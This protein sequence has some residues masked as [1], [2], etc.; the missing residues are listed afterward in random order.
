MM[1]RL[2]VLML[3]LLTG[4]YVSCSKKDSKESGVTEIIF[5]SSM[6]G[7]MAEAQ[8]KIV[9]G[10]NASQDKVKVTAIYQGSYFDMVAKLQAAFTAGDAPHLA[11]LEIA[12]I[13]MFADYGVLYDMTDLAKKA[14][15]DTSMFYPGLMTN[16]DWGEGLLALPFNRSTPM[17][18]YN[19]DMFREVGLDPDRPP[20]NWTELYEYSKRLSISDRRWGYC[21]PIDTWF[22]EAFIFQSNGTVFNADS[23]DIG[24]NNDSGIIPLRLWKQWI[25]EGVMKSP[26][27]QEYNSW[28]AA[29]LDFSAGIVGMIVSSSGDLEGLRRA[30][31][32]EIGTCFLPAN[33]RY[34]VPTG[35]AN[36]VMLTGHEKDAAAVMDFLKYATSPEPA[37]IWSIGT[38]YVP[39]SQAAVDTKVFQD[40]LVANPAAATVVNQLQYVMPR[41]NNRHYTQIHTETI[42]TEIQRCIMNTNITPEQTVQEISR[43]VRALLASK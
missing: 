2:L 9:D 34:G 14:G 16:S 38:G 33:I 4:F 28:E 10:Y 19:K 1:K 18:Y 40:Y 25:A 21:M 30:C 22:Y 36:I 35:G 29:R 23:T 24:F 43:Q 6:T 42:M 26:P 13:K 20:R 8:Q 27:G 37:A 39:T 31:D 7:F 41:P 5:W 15:I 32:F 12:R 11:M 17:F 3:I